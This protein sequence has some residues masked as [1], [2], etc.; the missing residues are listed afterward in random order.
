MGCFSWLDAKKPYKAVRQ[1]ETAYLLVPEEFEKTYGK[2][3]EELSYGCYGYFGSHN[4]YAMA[5]IFNRDHITEKNLEPAPRKEQYGGLWNFEREE[6]V[7]KG[8]SEVEIAEADDKKQTQNW[9]NA[10]RRREFSIK[11]LQDFAERKLSDEELCGKYGRDYLEEIGI[12]IS[13]YDDQNRALKYPIKIT[14]DPEAVYENV[15]P[16]RGDPNQGC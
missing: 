8:L 7:K 1:C 12:D 9:K 5:A 4:A 6:L 14:H 15:G 10:M 13:C 16:S 2:R 11:R 3:I